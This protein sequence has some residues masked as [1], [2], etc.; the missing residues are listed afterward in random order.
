[1]T[2]LEHGTS[3]EEEESWALVSGRLRL[4]EQLEDQFRCVCVY[5]VSPLT[6]FPYAEH[7]SLACSFCAAV[8]CSTQHA[9]TIARCCC[10]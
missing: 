6:L 5:S 2:A 7:T 10:G 8:F 4:T 9:F 1:M 3:E